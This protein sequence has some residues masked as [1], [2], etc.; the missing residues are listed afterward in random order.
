ML[1]TAA[2]ELGPNQWIPNILGSR[3]DPSSGVASILVLVF[4]SGIMAVGRQFAGPVVHSLSPTGMLL[5]SSIAAAIGLWLLGSASSTAAVFGA[6]AVFAI[7]ICYFWPTMLGFV[8][9]RLPRTGALGLAMMGGAGMLS[10]ASVLPV[11][12]R[13]FDQE[14]A[15][16]L[17]LGADLAKLRELAA[18]GATEAKNQLATAEVVGGAATLHYVVVLPIALCVVFACLWLRDRRRGGY[19]AE[20][21]AAAPPEAPAADERAMPG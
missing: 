16:A 12:G 11:M 14:T 4:V 10:A 15:A 18:S 7:G 3:L 9:E 17:P 1:M 21:L 8:A 19:R 5:G 6:A 13:F 2:T 20:T